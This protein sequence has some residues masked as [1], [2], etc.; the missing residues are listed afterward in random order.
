VLLLALLSFTVWTRVQ[1]LYL[2]LADTQ[3]EINV[4]NFYE[5]QIASS[6]NQQ[7]PNLPDANKQVLIDKELATFVSDNQV[8]LNEQVG[9]L[10][11]QI[12]SVYQDENGQTYL[13]GIDPYHYQRQVYYELEYGM[14][15]DTLGEEGNVVDSYRLAPLGRDYDDTFHAT[16]SALW[17]KFL[18]LFGDFTLNYSFFM[19][20]VLVVTLTV[21]SAY[22]FFSRE[23]SPLAAVVAGVV[24]ATSMFFVSRTTGESSDTDIYVLLFPFLTIW[25]YRL[26]KGK[27]ALVA[28]ALSGFLMGVYSYA[29]S[30]W[31]FTLV[32]FTFAIVVDLILKLVQKKEVGLHRAIIFH[33]VTF[34]STGF[35]KSPSNFFTAYMQ[36]L[37]SLL[38]FKSV[39]V[40]SL[41]PNIFTTVAELNA[42]G[43]DRVISQLGGQ[44]ILIL[45]LIG[46]CY[47]LYLAYK[48]R[49][50]F[51]AVYLLIWWLAAIYTTGKGI[52][53]ILLVIFPF[54]IGLAHFVQFILS[55]VPKAAFESLKIPVNITKSVSLVV[56]SIIF[57]PSIL[58]GVAIAQSSVPSMDDGWYN[59]LTFVRDNVSEDV[60]MTSWWD[61]GYWFRSVADRPVTFDGG[62]QVGYNAYW[63]GKALSSNEYLSTG[64]IRM[65]NCGQNT[66][67]ETLVNHTGGYQETID[68]LET[69]VVLPLAGAEKVF[70]ELGLP[71]ETLEYTHCDADNSIVVASGDMIGKSSVWG[72]FGAWNFTRAEMFQAVH[73]LPAPEALSILKNDYGLT[74]SIAVNE[75]NGMQQGGDNYISPYPQLLSSF[76]CSG[77]DELFCEVN[78]Q[79]LSL[80]VMYTKSTGAVNVSGNYDLEVV[81]VD[82]NIVFNDVDTGLG[83]YIDSTKSTGYLASVELVGGMFANMYY[84]GSS[85]CYNLLYTGQSNSAGKVMIWESDY[86]CLE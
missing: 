41:W 54:I 53:F 66:A 67:F 65:L 74:D 46:T 34:I 14:A 1:P 43:I 7:Y 72:H 19:V 75:Y 21:F 64:I 20:G 35:F 86:S 26:G 29:W 9:L 78:I 76:S 8:E 62:T 81:Q 32:L 60:I 28:A 22:L 80:T 6:I 38:N 85:D 51:I 33:I 61:F 24:L 48:K 63:V 77:D 68:I 79:S 40:T 71:M 45:S 82:N 58:S 57:L 49:D 50:Y 27:T 44:L 31:W 70:I 36:P 59:S 47:A 84:I 39:A 2:P 11:E 42:V 23:L 10:S 83:V 55:V 69:I 15:G 37:N 4:M 18:N 17:H 5:G 73:S 16:I 56:V 52:R 3:A 25:L 13:L 30:A 12:R